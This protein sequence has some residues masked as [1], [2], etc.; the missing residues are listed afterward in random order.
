[1]AIGD[2]LIQSVQ[3]IGHAFHLATIVA[4]SSITMLEDMK[5]G[6]DL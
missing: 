2:G 6:I 3:V 5:L 4:D 1:M